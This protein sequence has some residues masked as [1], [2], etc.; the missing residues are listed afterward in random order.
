MRRDIANEGKM[1]KTT[2][3]GLTCMA[4]VSCNPSQAFCEKSAECSEDD[5]DDSDDGEDDVAICVEVVDG[6]TDGLRANQEAECKA[7]ADAISAQRACQSGL[8]CED[9]NKEDDGGKCDDQGD[10]VNDRCQDISDADVDCESL[11]LFSCASI[12]SCDDAC[13]F[14]CDG[15]CDEPDLCAAGTDTTDCG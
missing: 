6:L 15:E 3:F 4:L 14:G 8:S 10:L 5:G 11:L 7:L 9:F 2:M 1:L 13:E 12:T